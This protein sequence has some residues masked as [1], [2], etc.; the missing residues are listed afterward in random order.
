MEWVL[1]VFGSVLLVVLLA[2]EVLLWALTALKWV[3]ALR[4]A[5]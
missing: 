3:R 2:L 5:N 4:G 1:A